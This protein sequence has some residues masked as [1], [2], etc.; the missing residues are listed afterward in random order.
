MA[1]SRELGYIVINV[2][3]R[4]FVSPSLSG[5]IYGQDAAQQLGGKRLLPRLPPFLFH[6][7]V[8]PCLR[9]RALH[10]SPAQSPLCCFAANACAYPK[11]ALA[12]CQVGGYSVLNVA[13]QHF[14]SPS[15]SGEICET[16]AA[17][18][19]KA[20]NG[21]PPFTAFIFGKILIAQKRNGRRL[22]ADAR[23]SFKQI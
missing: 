23:S 18:Q 13:L 19:N 9:R 1:R 15:L 8:A 10:F 2:A 6:Q 4:Q 14:V 3:L 7:Y 21:P 5:E 11:F 20:V 12:T 17:Q 22:L 16:S